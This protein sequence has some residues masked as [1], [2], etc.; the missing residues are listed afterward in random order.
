M[1]VQ[2]SS[3]RRCVHISG[4]RWPSAPWPKT[5]TT[6]GPNT[7]GQR[8]ARPPQLALSVAWQC[9]KSGRSGAGQGRSAGSGGCGTAGAARPSRGPPR[10]R[11]IGRSVPSPR[12]K[13]AGHAA[14][15][16]EQ[17]CQSL[18]EHVDARREQPGAAWGAPRR[19]LGHRRRTAARAPAVRIATPR[20][21]TRP[22]LKRTSDLRGRHPVWGA[23]LLACRVAAVTEAVLRAG[24][25]HFRSGRR[26]AGR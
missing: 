13:T 20:G 12:E 10:G 7:P 21:G 22:C 2:T 11:G 23:A 17:I 26:R 16:V 14:V 25:R 1:R 18:S 8:M 15:P 5:R 3:Q 19:V 9:G 6:R 4:R 24:I